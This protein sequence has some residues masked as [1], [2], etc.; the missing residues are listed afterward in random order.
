ML[1]P[2]LPEAAPLRCHRIRIES[3][4]VTV[5]VET[6][7]PKAACPICGQPSGRIHSR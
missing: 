3:A 5:L 7:G 2:L 6:T 1:N 4:L